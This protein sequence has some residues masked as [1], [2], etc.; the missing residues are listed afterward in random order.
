MMYSHDVDLICSNAKEIASAM[1]SNEVCIQHIVASAMKFGHVYSALEKSGVNMKEFIEALDAECE[2]CD[3]ISDSIAERYRDMNINRQLRLGSSVQNTLL[4]A[5]ALAENPSVWKT[6]WLEVSHLMM[7]IVGLGQCK[8]LMTYLDIDGEATSDILDAF[9]NN[10]VKH[11]AKERGISAKKLNFSVTNNEESQATGA[12]K[13]NSRKSNKDL[14]QFCTD[15]L[16][17]AETDDKPFVGRAEEL[18]SLMECLERRDKPNAI[19]VGPPGV[20]KTDV[21]RGLAKK[22][23]EGDVPKQLA[24]VNLYSVDIAGMLAGSEFRGAFEKKL[25]ETIEAACKQDRPILFI[26]EIHTVLGAGKTMDSAMD[27]ANILKPYLT[28]GKIRVI[29]ATTEEEYRKHVEKDAAFMRRFQNINVSEP[30]PNDSIT[31]LEGIKPA[32]EIFHNVKIN[33]DAIK[34]A[35]NLSVRHMHD[36]FLP[37]KAIDIIDQTCSRVKI[38]QGKKI[39]VSDIEITVSKMCK[40]P[41]HTVQKDDMDKVRTLDKKLKSQV[42]GQDEAIDKLTEAVQMSKAGLCD[43]TKPIGSFLFVGPSGVGKTEVSKQLA[44]T[45][46]IDFIRFDMSEYAEPHAVAKL[47][48]SPAGYVGYDDGGLLVEE[49]RKHPNSVVLF[50]EIEKAHPDI[51]KIFL[52]ILDYG[53]LS[54][55]KGRKADF[56]NTVIIMTSN[57]GNSAA[58]KSRIGFGEKMAEDRKSTSMQAVKELMAPELRGRISATI[59]FSPLNKDVAKM[60]VNKELNKLAIKLKAKGITAKYTDAA[61]DEIIKRGVSAQYGARE[62]QRVIDN[63]IKKMFVKQIISG[64][65][66]QNYTVDVVCDQFVATSIQE[67]SKKAAIATM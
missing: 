21:V 8:S 38:E 59:V 29:G 39:T 3:K 32:Y 65:T 46:G 41:A 31:I 53:M 5:K 23:I 9:L 20:G 51:Y 6:T 60:I 35:V 33:K 52:Q 7:A 37:D 36:R 1:N 27:A 57:A 66:G 34:A 47:I 62:I 26:D 18:A 58:E 56:R 61:I 67:K 11:E 4:R 2:G 64:K 13:R 19:L 42:F 25:K 49:I 17:N 45:L 50:D 54:D 16:A 22:I 63:D 14:T 43:E 15:L 44:A 30:T 48:G 12:P 40:I 10:L 55:N 28:Q 24:N